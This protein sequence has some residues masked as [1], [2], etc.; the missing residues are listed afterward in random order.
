[1]VDK[2]NLFRVGQIINTHGIGGELKI[3]LITDFPEQRFKIGNQLFL[4]ND[5]EFVDQLIIKTSRAYKNNWLISFE[6]LLDINL[7][8][9]YKN[10]ELYAEGLDLDIDS[11]QYL[12]SQLIGLQVNDQQRGLI[13]E[14][15]EILSMPANDVWVVNGVF[16][17]ILLP[18]IDQVIKE[19]DLD[20]QKV[21]VELLEGLIDEN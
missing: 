21:E 13:G 19:V 7:V 6:N 18:V 8:E 4:F 17:E 3:N 1:M 15:V 2:N 10:F 5:S 14:I 11:G 12:Y 20:N 9:K 16:G